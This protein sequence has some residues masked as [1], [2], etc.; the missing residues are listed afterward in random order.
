VNWNVVPG[1]A[2]E[3]VTFQLL[4]TLTDSGKV[5]VTVQ[6]LTCVVPLFVTVTST[7]KKVPPVFDGAAV[8]V[9]AAKACPP[10]ISPDS[11]MPSFSKVFIGFTPLSL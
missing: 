10:N 1:L 2:P 5:S 4:F 6:P 11:N 7:W 8:Q 9:Y 3:R